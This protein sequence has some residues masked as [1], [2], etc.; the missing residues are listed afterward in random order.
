ME[1]FVWLPEFASIHYSKCGCAHPLSDHIPATKQ[2]FPSFSLFLMHYLKFKHVSTKI[3]TI[4]QTYQDYFTRRLQE[5]FPAPQINE[6]PKL[7]TSF[8]EGHHA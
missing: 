6:F 5:N 1:N 8:T 7:F 3:F 2:K 4:K